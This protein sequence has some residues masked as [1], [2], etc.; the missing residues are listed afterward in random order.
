MQ[1]T[2]VQLGRGRTR[3]PLRHDSASAQDGAAVRGQP[4]TWAALT[5]PFV[6]R[7]LYMERG[8]MEPGNRAAEQRGRQTKEEGKGK[9]LFAAGWTYTC[10][11][12][13]RY[14]STMGEQ[15]QR[16]G[17]YRKGERLLS[18]LRGEM[19]VITAAWPSIIIHCVIY[20]PESNIYEPIV[21]YGK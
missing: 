20:S 6:L 2:V 8:R 5:W 21:H 1:K 11:W 9:V 18:L 3:R 13:V 14:R 12:R 7:A 16:A 17:K 19:G 4:R 15:E 10:R